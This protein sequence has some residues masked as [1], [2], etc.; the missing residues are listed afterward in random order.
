MCFTIHIQDDTCLHMSVHLSTDRHHYTINM[1]TQILVASPC[2]IRQEIHMTER[3]TQIDDGDRFR[4][5]S[6]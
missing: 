6:R 3:E 5:V 4:E 1:R 2:N